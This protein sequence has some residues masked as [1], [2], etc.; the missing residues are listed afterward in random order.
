VLIVKI[1]LILPLLMIALI[2]LVFTHRGLRAGNEAWGRRL[3][4]LVTAEIVLTLSVLG[5]VGVLTSISPARN[6]LA[7][8]AAA[9]PPA[10]TNDLLT[11]QSSDDLHI[12]LNIYPGWVGQNTF[13]VSL[14][15]NDMDGKEVSDASLIR[16]RFDSLDQDI[17]TSEL[18]PQNQGDGNY[19]AAGANLSVPG[20]WR[21]RMTVQRP[22]KYDAVTNFNVNMQLPP[23]LPPPPLID[24]APVL[25]E[26]AVAFLLAGV[27]ALAAAG[28]FIGENRL[29]LRLSSGAVLLTGGLFIGGCLFL[30]SGVRAIQAMANTAPLEAPQLSENAPI[31]LAIQYKGS[32]PHLLTVNGVLL[33]PDDSGIWRPMQP[34][35]KVTDLYIDPIG[36][37][38]TATDAGMR[39][40]MSGAWQKVD[41]VPEQRIKPLHGYMLT[42]GVGKKMARLPSGNYLDLKNLLHLTAPPA[43]EPP[44]DLVMLGDHSFTMQ[45][46]QRLFQTFDGAQTWASL[47]APAPVNAIGANLDGNLLVSTPKG[48]YTW[49]YDTK[50][51]DAALPLPDG[52]PVTVMDNSADQ[53]FALAGG[54]LYRQ[55]GKDWTRIDLPDSQGA[56]LTS[57][58]F[59]YPDTFWVLDVAGA[60]LWSST[61]GDHWT[62]TSIVVKSD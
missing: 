3:R 27:V 51:W 29:R 25:S 48:M 16:L 4:G 33:R 24:P 58:Q 41:D 13:T 40:Y 2:N 28:F 7:V 49:N 11:M 1:V 30:V 12:H 6:T 57:L 19:V 23:P 22:G 54:R 34:G 62:L 42:F 21:I 52:Q 36:N 39:V 35:A 38:W 8:R 45:S 44:S 50:S 37:I 55:D 5:A 20:N 26:R 18:R 32:L 10:P 56:Y 59:Q 15:Q 61:D 31:K 47:D 53:L 46:D 9:P 17:G 14:L 60:R 43:D